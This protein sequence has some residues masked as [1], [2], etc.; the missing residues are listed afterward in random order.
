MENDP[1]YLFQALTW[2]ASLGVLSVAGNV[3][4]GVIEKCVLVIIT[5]ILYLFSRYDHSYI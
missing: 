3:C 1:N 2:K 5:H 4:R